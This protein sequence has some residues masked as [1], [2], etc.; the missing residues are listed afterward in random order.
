MGPKEVQFVVTWCLQC[1]S[2]SISKAADQPLHLSSCHPE[3][4]CVCTGHPSVTAI[5]PLLTQ[6]L[7][8]KTEG[9]RRDGAR[10]ITFSCLLALPHLSYLLLPVPVLWEKGD[11]IISIEL[12]VPAP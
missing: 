5:C 2:Y 7:T 4:L 12:T 6:T 11:C 8:E 1:I 10:P 9:R 3:D